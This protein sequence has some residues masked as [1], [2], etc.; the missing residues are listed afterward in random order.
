MVNVER[1]GK[2]AAVGVVVVDDSPEQCAREVVGRFEGCF[3]LGIH[4]RVSGHHNIS[5]A[6]NLAIGTASEMADWVAMT[7]D[8]C[9]PEPDWLEVFLDVQRRTGADAVAGR[10]RAALPRARPRG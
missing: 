6:R 10:F 7:D 9:E 8:D 2:R 3:E 1:L 5:L 4:Y